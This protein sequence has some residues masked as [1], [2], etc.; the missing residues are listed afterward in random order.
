MYY[1][2]IQINKDVDLCGFMSVDISSRSQTM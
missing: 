1:E 2:R